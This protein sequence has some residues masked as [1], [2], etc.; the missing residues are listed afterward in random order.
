MKLF[1]GGYELA[2]ELAT[3]N[4][5]KIQECPIAKKAKEITKTIK[6]AVSLLKAMR[7]RA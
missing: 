1:E 6:E 3:S 5:P 7:G 2:L 4:C